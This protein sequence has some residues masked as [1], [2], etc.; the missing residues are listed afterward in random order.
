MYVVGLTE[1]WMSFA[2]E[3]ALT[4]LLLAKRTIPQSEEN[5]KSALQFSSIYPNAHQQHLADIALPSSGAICQQ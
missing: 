5:K 2:L 1:F 4:F 3:R